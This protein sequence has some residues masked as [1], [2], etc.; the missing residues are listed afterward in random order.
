[1]KLRGSKIAEGGPGVAS[2]ASSLAL[3]VLPVV[4]A[5]KSLGQV[6]SGTDLVT[7][8]P[9]SRGMEAVGIVAGLVPGG[10]GILKAGSKLLK[11]V[12]PKVAAQAAEDIKSGKALKLTD[13][14]S[15]HALEKFN[16]TPPQ[17]GA[18][19]KE[20]APQLS[21]MN[22]KQFL[23]TMDAE[24]KAG[25]CTKAAQE[26][27]SPLGGKQSMTKYEYPD[28][29]LV[30]YKPEGDEIRKGKPTYSVE[31][32]KDPTLPDQGLQDVA[33]KVNENGH[34]VPKKPGEINYP[35][36]YPK[37]SAEFADYRELMMSAGHKELPK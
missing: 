4:G 29:T 20:L 26:I 6:F 30:R 15:K 1:L 7:G 33:F 8:E 21:K 23:E 28:G 31:V 14:Q 16:M 35:K 18:A 34:A 22:E 9:V 5:L 13:P 17:T 2:Q 32:K 24:V 36:E 10:K 12:D 27:G 11:K 25:K 37:S 3:D 19:A